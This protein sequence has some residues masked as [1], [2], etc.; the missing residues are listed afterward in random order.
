MQLQ[1]PRNQCTL[2]ASEGTTNRKVYTSPP[3]PPAAAALSSL[4]L[5]LLVVLV[6][7]ALKKNHPHNSTTGF[8]LWPYSGIQDIEQQEHKHQCSYNIQ[9]FWK[10]IP[11]GTSL[12]GIRPFSPGKL[13]R[14]LQLGLLWSD[15]SSPQLHLENVK[16]IHRWINNNLNTVL[17]PSSSYALLSTSQGP[18]N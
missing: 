6:T 14:R 13:Y 9:K 4:L 15:S 7:L 18:H 16:Q 5:L 8:I 11:M 2:L 10:F 12:G 17:S 1:V 3:P